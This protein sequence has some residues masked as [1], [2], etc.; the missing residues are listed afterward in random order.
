MAAPFPPPMCDSSGALDAGG[1]AS[2]MSTPSDDAGSHHVGSDDAG[3]VNVTPDRDAGSDAAQT[4][5]APDGS[6]PPDGG[7]DAHVPEVID[8][9]SFFWQCVSGPCAWGTEGNAYGVAWPAELHPQNARMLYS[10]SAPIY[11][12]ATAAEG[13]TLHGVEGSAGIYAG[14]TSAESHRPLG[15][16]GP[17]ISL[18]I[19][20]LQPDD[21]VSVQSDSPFSYTLELP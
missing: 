13:I 2:Q 17:G 16:I 15:T 19:T 1:D 10:N 3:Q 4:P 18:T 6:V 20:N 9:A 7:S 5:A 21:L 12:G 8:A 11:L 14:S